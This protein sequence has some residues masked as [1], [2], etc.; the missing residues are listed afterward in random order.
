MKIMLIV[1][2]LTFGADATTT[3]YALKH[4]GTEVIIPSQNPFVVD[5]AVAAESLSTSLMLIKINKNHPKAAK[6]IG[7]SIIGARGFVVAHNINELRK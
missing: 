2:N 7:W 3:H 1:L 6:L 4:N 5:G